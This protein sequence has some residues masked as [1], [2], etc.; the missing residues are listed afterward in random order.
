MDEVIKNVEGMIKS[1]R[2]AQ[3]KIESKNI[4]TKVIQKCDL[5]PVQRRL[6]T[7]QNDVTEVL[8]MVYVLYGTAIIICFVVGAI[9]GLL[10]KYVNVLHRKMARNVDM[11]LLYQRSLNQKFLELELVSESDHSS[12][13]E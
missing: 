7:I 10:L 2:D 11:V 4:E 9:L 8:E 12:S 3:D 6:D 5:K 13:S 1:Y